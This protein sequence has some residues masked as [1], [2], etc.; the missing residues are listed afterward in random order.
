M[1]Y[2]NLAFDI[3][4]LDKCDDLNNRLEQEL[5]NLGQGVRSDLQ[6][7]RNIPFGHH[8]IEATRPLN[9]EC[10]FI[11]GKSRL[12]TTGENGDCPVCD[13][14]GLRDCGPDEDEFGNIFI[15]T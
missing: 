2:C 5:D 11:D 9:V 3:R 8:H 14:I 6:E 13:N 7:N 1:H 4:S 10:R 15:P 12:C